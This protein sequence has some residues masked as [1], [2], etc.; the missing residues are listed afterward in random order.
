VVTF[1][2]VASISAAPTY[3]VRVAPTGRYL[4]D[5]NGVP[6]LITGESPQAMI[7]DLSEADAELFF[8]NRHAHGFNTV[9]INL[10]CASYTG[11]H[12]D[13]STLD[14][15]PPF[16]VSNDFSTPNE[17][18]FARA[19]RILRLAAQYG[20]LVILDPAETGSW[21][22]VMQDNGV[23]KCRA[24]GRY[25][26]QRYA[27][28]DNIL[29]MHGNDYQA[30]GSDNDQY[31]TAVALGIQDFDDRHLHTVELDFPVSGSLDDPSWAP[32]IQL[33]ASYT[34]APTYQQVLVDYNRAGPVPT[35]LVEASYEFENTG[36]PQI[37]RAQAY[38]SILSGAT[39]HL[40]GNHYT[41]QFIDGWKDQLDTPGATQ[42]AYFKALFEPRAW[43]DLVPD[44]SNAV[45]TT[46][47]GT[48]G[49]DDY[50]TAART[51]DGNLVIAYV[52]SARTITVDMGAL[53][54]PVMAR[55]YDPASGGFLAISGSLLTNA[56]ALDFTTPGD[57]ADGP[58]NEDWVLVLEVPTA[59]T[60][61]VQGHYATPQ[62]PQASVAVTYRAA[63]MAG[64]L[65]V[66]IVGWNDSSTSV[67]SVTDTHGNV[68]V[69]AVG[70]TVQPGPPGSGGLSQ[71]IYYAGNIARAA[72]GGNTVDVR[73]DAAVAYPD[74]RIL[75]YRGLD[76]TSPLDG[77][78]GQAGNS[79]TSD[80]GTLITANA[81]DLLIAANTVFTLTAGPTTGFTS[82]MITSPDGDMAE[83]AVVTGSRS[84]R[85]TTPLTGTGPWV[86]QM[87]GFKAAP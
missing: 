63:Q 30:W 26:G 22:S 40:Y 74:V 1:V 83:D 48:F 77:A 44:Q 45:I 85:A 81:S 55:W 23:E 67:S 68:Y 72:A 19:D 69:R 17:A 51:P 12:S 80:S 31:T 52:P 43:Y 35:F 58:G 29:W 73:F 49:S 7:G 61:F 5:Q 21:L 82:R 38:W 6:F 56:G 86:M 11:C 36:T 13:G 75:E 33:N 9:W 60:A 3:P 54:A 41:W 50:V 76:T 27:A 64:N 78:T 2:I 84:Y 4:V 32:I 59:A 65:N 47:V 10:L 57:N 28:F 66:V 71:S 70:P 62:T 15:I 14:G 46:G 25:L 24:Y 37:L 18:Y 20:F 42:M 34:Y 39:G 8:A 87:V 53:A 16:T 79:A